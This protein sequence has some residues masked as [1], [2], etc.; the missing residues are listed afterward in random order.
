MVVKNICCIG[1][2]YV[3]GP[4]CSVIAHKCP[5]IKV[6]VADKSPERIKQWNSDEL[7]IY[8]PQLDDIVKSCR[9]R[10][11]F[12]S[13]DIDKAIQEADLIFISVNT[14]TKNYG[15]GK[16]RAADLQYVE[17]A[18]RSIAEKATTPK[19][20]VEKSTVPVKAAESISRIL[21]ANII[22]GANFQVLS[23]PEF[24]AEA[25]LLR[26]YLTQTASSLGESRHPKARQLFKSC[27]L[28]T[29][30]GFLKIVSSP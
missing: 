18:A 17:A 13:C 23:N 14:P 29:S 9:G 3:G 8:E 7:P 10:N 4:T 21:K 5:D 11:L 30:T 19:I 26:T 15:F 1:A 25:Q 27:V 28:C 6:V 24:L 16:G 12:F 22:Q 20:V 2:G